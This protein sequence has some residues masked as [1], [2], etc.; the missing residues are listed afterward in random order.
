MA[1]NYEYVFV[2]IDLDTNMCI[3]IETTTDATQGELPGMVQVPT[4]DEGY[5][6][7]Y[8]NWDD[9]KFYYDAEYT[10][11]YVSPLL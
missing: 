9:E 3:G 6:F 5:V 7:K 8:Y 11:E 1:V 10:Q 2:C 4:Y